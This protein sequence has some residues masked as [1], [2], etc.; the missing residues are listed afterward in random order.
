M[1]HINCECEHYHKLHWLTM[2]TKHIPSETIGRLFPYL[3]VL[4][5]LKKEGEEIA[6]SYRLSEICNIKPSIIRKDLSY[7]GDFGI[8]G[9]GY[10]VDNLI[11]KI[12]G[13]LNLDNA[14]KVALVGVGN[15][16]KALLSYS[17]FE[18]E[19][20]KIVI[21][22]DNRQDKIGNKIN[23]IAVEDMANLEDKIRSENIQL[24][25][26]AVPEEAAP[27][28]AQRLARAGVNSILSFAPC[29]LTRPDNINISCVDLSTE[30]AR[31]V[32]LSS[33]ENITGKP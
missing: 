30:M 27:P 31:L 13:I 32:Y 15:I 28:I 5:C 17:N 8:R 11:K 10:D 14:R 22:F 6:S 2:K 26:L 24:V 7:F 21:A 12:R 4:M 23:N 18:L 33:G 29:Q 16:G 25:I 1:L 20:F 3:R 19:G 9:V